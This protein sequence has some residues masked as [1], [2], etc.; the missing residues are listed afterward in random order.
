VA[1]RLTLF[2]LISIIAPLLD[3]THPLFSLTLVVS[4][5]P[6][7]ILQILTVPF[8]VYIIEKKYPHW[9]L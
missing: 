9:K 7:V 4:G 6:G 5:F 2:F 8:T 1:D 3:I